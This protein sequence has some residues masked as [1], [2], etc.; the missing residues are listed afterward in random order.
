MTLADLDRFDPGAV[1][2]LGERAV[3]IG[4]SMA[5]LCTARVLAE[6]FDEVVVL[7]RDGLT[8][9]PTDRPGAP[10]VR[11]PHAM[12]EAGRATLEDFF[13][14]FGQSLIGT[15][16]LMIDASTEMLYYG[17]GDFLTDAP[18]RLPMYCASRRLFETV[19]RQEIGSFDNVVLRGNCCVVGY[20]HEDGAVTGVQFRDEAGTQSIV[21]ADLVVDAS[22]RTSKTTSWLEANGYPRPELEE[23]VVDVTYGSVRIDRPPEDRRTFFVPPESPRTRGAAA[24]PIENDQWEVICQGIHGD[25]VPSEP[26]EFVEFAESL[27]VSEIGDLLA[28]RTWTSDGV[29]TYP[30]PSSI[31]HRYDRLDRFPDGLVVTGDAIASFNPIYGQGM[32]LAALEALVLHH[33]LA[34][35]GL[36]SLAHRF[37]D[38][39]APVIDAAWRVSVGGDFA[40]PQTEGDRPFG[41]GL[42][43]RYTERLIRKA[44]SDGRLTDTFQRV[45]RLEQPP[46]T[47]LRPGVV[48]RVMR[49]W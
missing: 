21:E 41:I 37:F 26:E 2:D 49:P 10:Q 9:R 47:M 14:G 23:V 36:D 42:F 43:N 46:R 4:G 28:D 33:Q 38:R 12:L 18:E 13:P 20:Q 22:G 29:H 17:G 40:F 8:G 25:E 24:I 5:G 1:S 11:H 39:S 44:H 6:G 15:G 45:F 34:A 35:G 31:R 27:P 3:V 48:W 19:V 16:G 32:S 30:F 7:E